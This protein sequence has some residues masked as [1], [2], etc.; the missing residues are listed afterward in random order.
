MKLHLCPVGER[1]GIEARSSRDQALLFRLL[2]DIDRPAESRG[3]IQEIITCAHALKRLSAR[4]KVNQIIGST[5][6]DSVDTVIAD[7]TVR[8]DASQA[9]GEKTT[10]LLFDFR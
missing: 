9:I 1:L 6:Q 8:E 3:D 10:D 5:R 4:P 2:N 7:A